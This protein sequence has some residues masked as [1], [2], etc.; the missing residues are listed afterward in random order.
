MLP[1]NSSAASPRAVIRRSRCLP[2]AAPL[3]AP[4]PDVILDVAEGGESPANPRE[5]STTHWYIPLSIRDTDSMI[6][7]CFG[8]VELVWTFGLWQISP[9]TQVDSVSRLDTDQNPLL[10]RGVPALENASV[11]AFRCPQPPP[12][13]ILSNW[14]SR[15]VDTLEMPPPGDIT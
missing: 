8:G 13:R 10:S 6:S 2:V 11:S 7:S 12:P 4:C 9:S 1:P 3:S 14:P 15:A 5:A